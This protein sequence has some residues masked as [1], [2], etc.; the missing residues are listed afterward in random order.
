MKTPSEEYE[1]RILRG[2]HYIDKIIKKKMMDNE[3]IWY[4]RIY[5]ENLKK[6]L[7]GKEDKK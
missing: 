1:D 3:H 5:L 6:I 2:T 4:Y 7:L